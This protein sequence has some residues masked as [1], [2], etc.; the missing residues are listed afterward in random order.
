MPV[1][2]SDQGVGLGAG[3]VMLSSDMFYQFIDWRHDQ[4]DPNE[5]FDHKGTLATSLIVPKITIG[6]S[7]W[8][9]ISFQ[10]VLGDRHMGWDLPD[11]STHHRPEHSHS[12]FLNAVGGYLG[13][14]R[15][16][17]RYLALNTGRG[18]GSRLFIGFGV[19]IP[20]KNTLTKSPFDKDEEENY[21]EHRHFAMTDGVHKGQF[22]LQYYYKKITNPVFLGG[23]VK[24][25]E[26]LYD[27]KYGFSGSRLSE[28]SLSLLFNKNNPL[29]VPISTNIVI[30]HEAE[31]FW[32]GSPAPNSEN[33]IMTPGIGFFFSSNFAT[34][35]LNIQK[36]YYLNSAIS[37]EGG[38]DYHEE[39][40]VWQVSLSM[41]KI[42]D[43]TIPWLYW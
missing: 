1:G 30:S 8:W 4:I 24:I 9:N 25:A 13:D 7:D 17:L 33:T 20:S 18:V 28:F 32:N 37:E 40:H 12:N 11:S 34:L 3:D 26:P 5:P 23:T 10:Q 21:F 43:Y 41:R 35:T 6:L 31:A 42:L 2:N 19:A 27:N 38:T 29:K 16:M 36:P 39:A 14:S 15:L 22:E